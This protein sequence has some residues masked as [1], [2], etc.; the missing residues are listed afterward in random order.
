MIRKFNYTGRQKIKRSNIEITIHG[1]GRTMSFD[2]QVELNG[3]G[4][5]SEATVYIEPYYHFSFMRFNCGTVENFSLPA[6]TIL[7]DLPLTDILYFR[8]KIV[9]ESG[10]H[11][12]LLAYADQLKPTTLEDGQI[13]RKSILPVQFS[14]DLGQQVWKVSFDEHTPTLHI[15]RRIENKRE[16]VKSNEFISLAYPSVVKE[17]VTK[18]VHEFPEYDEDGDHWA[19]LWLQFTKQILHVHDKPSP[20]E[21]NPDD[22]LEWVVSVVEAF[23]R[24]YTV[25]NRYES[26]NLVK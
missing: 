26:S 17:V 10:R 7:A 19:C 16:L 3:L 8:V 6:N 12:R 22:M 24:K 4:L 13:R 2:A 25:R 9:D 20:D 18:I 14:T 23:C 11:G 5:P 15:N 1:Q 21:G